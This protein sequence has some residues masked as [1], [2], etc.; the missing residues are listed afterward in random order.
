MKGH[1]YTKA[2]A[3]IQDLGQS[4]FLYEISEEIFH[5]NL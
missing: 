3:K 4:I 2:L 1:K 5:P